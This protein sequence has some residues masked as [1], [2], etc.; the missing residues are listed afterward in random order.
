MPMKVYLT[1]TDINIS[2]IITDSN[3]YNIKQNL[4]GKNLKIRRKISITKVAGVVVT[5][6]GFEFNFL[7]PDEQDLRLLS[8]CFF[9]CIFFYSYRP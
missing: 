1:Y 9:M 5:T 6:N 4:L 3:I 8:L 2:N 7:V